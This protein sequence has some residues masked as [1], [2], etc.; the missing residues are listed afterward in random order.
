ML[1]AVHLPSAS[2]IASHFVHTSTAQ[3]YLEFR[4]LGLG[5]VMWVTNRKEKCERAE[6]IFPGELG[7]GWSTQK[8]P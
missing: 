7:C 3:A 1:S 8:F 2:S 4:H 6:H 5:H